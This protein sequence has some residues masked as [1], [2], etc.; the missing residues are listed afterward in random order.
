[1]FLARHS[2][3][4]TPRCK[5]HPGRE[6][7]PL[8]LDDWASALL[9]DSTKISRPLS[10]PRVF[11]HVAFSRL[12]SSSPDFKCHKSPHAEA[13]AIPLLGV[14]SLTLTTMRLANGHGY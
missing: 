9:K 13:R 8:R 11:D 12:N 5:P 6:V 14:H 3:S 1:M 4:L 2:A 10:A 7:Q